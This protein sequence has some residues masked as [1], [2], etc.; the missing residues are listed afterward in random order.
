MSSVHPVT[1]SSTTTTGGTTGKTRYRR[2]AVAVLLSVW[3]VAVL[4]GMKVLFDHESAPGDAADAPKRW[5]SA[6][7]VSLQSERYQLIMLAHPHCPCTRA[8]LS[9]LAR[10]MRR[11]GDRVATTVLFVKP[12]EGLGDEWAFTDLWSTAERIENVTPV[13]DDGGREAAFFGAKTS[14]QTVLYSPRGDLLFSGGITSSRGH[15]GDNVGSQRIVSLV[16]R[17]A[18]ERAVSAVFGCPLF[19][20]EP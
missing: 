13:L 2:A 9:E 4:S 14:G 18:A 6:S 7:S 17:G 3:C 5:P 15:E 19:D 12:S 20:G 11:V 8:S 10:L 1:T 16:E